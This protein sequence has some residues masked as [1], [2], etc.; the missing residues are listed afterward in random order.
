MNAPVYH[1]IPEIA[2]ASPTL[3]PDQPPQPTEDEPV[4]LRPRGGRGIL[5][6]TFFDP[7]N[8]VSVALLGTSLVLVVLAMRARQSPDV[9]MALLL[10][11]FL[12]AFMRAYFF[13]YY[14]GRRFTLLVYMVILFAGLGV[15]GILWLDR[16]PA[17]EVIRETIVTVPEAPGY[18][19]AAIC[20]LA[21]VVTIFIH[22]VLPKRWLMRATDEVASQLADEDLLGDAPP[23]EEISRP[24]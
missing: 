13:V 14:H 5:G 8:L 9:L 23:V 18:I 6:W 16:A 1:L 22:F 2:L 24:G 20:H 21:I 3:P 10:Y 4:I 19:T 7:A 17:H 15:S 12:A 11:L